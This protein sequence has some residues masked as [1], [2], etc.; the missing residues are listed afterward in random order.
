P[1]TSR[2]SV[3]LPHP[4][5][6]TSTSVVRGATARRGTSTTVTAPKRFR[7]ST[8]STPPARG[9]EAMALHGPWPARPG[10]R[11]GTSWRG[12][13]SSGTASSRRRRR[14]PRATWEAATLEGGRVAGKLRFDVLI[15]GGGQAGN[16]LAHALAARGQSVALAERARLGGSCVNFG[17]TPTKAA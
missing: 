16:P 9:F 12:S 6:P 13:L 4:L 7:S 15:I 5:G 10:S 1:T 11:S 14:T 3:L 2:N 17:C 8:T